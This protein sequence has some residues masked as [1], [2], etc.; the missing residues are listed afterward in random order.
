[1]KTIIKRRITKI[2]LALVFIVIVIL[3]SKRLVSPKIE[4]LVNKV[5]RDELEAKVVK[6][7][8]ALEIRTMERDMCDSSL[9]TM[10]A[11]VE[12]LKKDACVI[13]EKGLNGEP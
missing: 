9:N 10:T 12:E 8:R 11:E 3:V 6:Q 7:E 13:V 2:L 4:S 1:M 5:T